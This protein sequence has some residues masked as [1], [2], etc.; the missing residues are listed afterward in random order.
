MKITKQKRKALEES[1]LQALDTHDQ[2]IVLAIAVI[3]ERVK[4]LPAEDRKDLFKLAKEL[5]NAENSEEITYIVDSMREIIEDALPGVHKMEQPEDHERPLPGLKK[6]IDYA[7]DRIRKERKKAGM[8]QEELALAAGL[9]QSHISRLESGLHSPSHA[10]L[11]KIAH[12]LG[13]SVKVF[14]PCA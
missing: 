7:S 10:T 3:A 11:A 12:A 1:A 9:P 4:R 8:T 6:W 2:A 5:P 13:I 14:D